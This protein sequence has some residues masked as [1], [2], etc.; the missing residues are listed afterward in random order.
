MN[1]HA[2]AEVP[3]LTAIVPAGDR[4]YTLDLC[5]RA[6]LAAAEAPEEL[7]VVDRPTGH[8][9]A[10]LRNA[11]AHRATG[12]VLV[13]VDADVE[14]HPDA[15]ARI[16]HAF[17]A[18]PS[19]VALF[20]AY[21]D[22]PAAPGVVSAFRNLLHHHIHQTGAGAATTFWS[23]LGAIRR[24]AFL[25][26]G[27]FDADR[28]PGASVEDIEL[29]MTLFADG[30]R[31]RLDPRLLGTHHKRWSLVGMVRSDLLDRGVPWARALLRAG[32]G[33]RALNLSWSQRVSALASLGVLGA[34]AAGRPRALAA[35][36]GVL[37]ALNRSFYALLWRRMGPPRALAGVGLHVL[38]HLTAALAA[39]L[40]IAGEAWERGRTW[41]GSQA[42]DRGRTGR[43]RGPAA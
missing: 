41:R 33:S 27:G 36:L 24:E 28:Y 39:I 40:A 7:L 21:D 25:G 18:D 15:F 16:R 3:S 29:G 30:A 32:H 14:V 13:F 11:G 22:A 37:T 6:I 42:R 4:P 20:G 43:A 2:G 35:A 38:H 1:G 17:A 34:M 19:L 12:E 5:R 23:G 31:L 26:A 10:A 9:P 8:G